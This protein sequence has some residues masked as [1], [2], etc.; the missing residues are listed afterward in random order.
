MT[1]R[2]CAGCG[3]KSTPR[4]GAVM[5]IND[6]Y[7]HRRCF[8]RASPEQRQAADNETRAY[9]GQPPIERK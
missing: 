5:A 6:A 1:G 7:W 3:G 8:E 9:R 2:V 4:K